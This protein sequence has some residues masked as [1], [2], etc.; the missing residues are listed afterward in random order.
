MRS[1]LT[2]ETKSSQ[3]GIEHT[4]H[5]SSQEAETGG[6]L[7]LRPARSMEVVLGQPGL[8]REILPQ[9]TTTIKQTNPPQNR[10]RT[11]HFEKIS[12]LKTMQIQGKTIK[13]ALSIMVRKFRSL[14]VKLVIHLLLP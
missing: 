11:I 2:K 9:T 5:H 3:V 10:A 12:N 14:S 7:N 6:S 8:H 1:G 4:F 13:Q